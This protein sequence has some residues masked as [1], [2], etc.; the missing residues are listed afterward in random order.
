MP[1]AAGASS[2]AL[3]TARGRLPRPC[4]RQ[5]Y[6]M[7]GAVATARGEN[8]STRAL[9]VRL[10]CAANASPYGSAVAAINS[11]SRCSFRSIVR[12]SANAAIIALAS[13]YAPVTVTAVSDRHYDLAQQ[14]RAS[15][16]QASW[17]PARMATSSCVKRSCARN[18]RGHCNLVKYCACSPVTR[19]R[20]CDSTSRMLL[21]ALS[22][23]DGYTARPSSFT[24]A[25]QKRRPGYRSHQTS[26]Q[27][28]VNLTWNASRRAHAAGHTLRRSQAALDRLRRLAG[29][30]P[31]QQV[32]A[33]SRASDFA[34]EPVSTRLPRRWQRRRC[35][36]PWP[37]RTRASR[38]PRWQ[39]RQ[40]RPLPSQ[41][42][43]APAR[44]PCA[45]PRPPKPPADA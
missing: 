2:G 6:G 24:I 12:L 28:C 9:L 39:R 26:P 19:R 7:S 25:G 30:Q 38:P 4:R 16:L 32:L 18:R 31:L 8:V 29:P 42:S 21:T 27:S 34:A 37:S 41:R 43:S 45:R 13:V 3:P 35:A 17:A 14:H 1:P 44:A 40:W 20:R 23:A 33:D 5:T 36:L 11:L 10:C 15:H 22:T